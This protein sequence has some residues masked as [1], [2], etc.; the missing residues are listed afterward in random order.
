MGGVAGWIRSDCFKGYK[1]S[2]IIW[3]RFQY[4]YN[5]VS[6][7]GNTILYNWN[8]L[9]EVKLK[10]SQIQTKNVKQLWWCVLTRW[11]EFFHSAHVYQIITMHILNFLQLYLSI[12]SLKGEKRKYKSYTM[13][14]DCI[15]DQCRKINYFI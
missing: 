1:L 12:L 2:A 11:E 5:M 14:Y 9:T 8:F 6:I 7:V 15:Y 4:L 10:Y 3:V 13:G